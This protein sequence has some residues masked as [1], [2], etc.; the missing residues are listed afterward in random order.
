MGEGPNQLRLRSQSLRLTGRDAQERQRRSLPR[1]NQ[2]PKTGDAIIIQGPPDKYGH[3]TS[4]IFLALDDGEWSSGTKGTWRVAET[5]QIDNGGHIA[6]HN[7]EYAGTKW[8]VGNRWMLGWLDLD[9]INFGP[10]REKTQDYLS[11]FSRSVV[12]PYA[13]DVIGIWKVTSQ[14]G[15]TWYYFFFKGFRIFYSEAAKPTI[16]QEGGYWVPQA[17]ITIHWDS[18]NNEQMA[19]P[20]KSAATGSDNN[21]PWKATKVTSNAVIMGTYNNNQGQRF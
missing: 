12:S 20:I 17:A 5:G 3:D 9:K 8:M 21:G 7:V 4:H 15:E 13:K 10:P 18:G 6:H 11:R 14:H 2:Y 19:L 16:L 1:G